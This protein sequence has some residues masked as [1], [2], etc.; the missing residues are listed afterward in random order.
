MKSKLVRVYFLNNG[1]VL[2]NATEPNKGK[3][4]FIARQPAKNFGEFL[5]SNYSEVELGQAILKVRKKCKK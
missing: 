1:Q 2:I 4:Q 5:S 3:T